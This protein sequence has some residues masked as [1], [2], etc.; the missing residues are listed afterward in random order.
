[1]RAAMSAFNTARRHRPRSRSRVPASRSMS[2]RVAGLA[3]VGGL[4]WALSDPGAAQNV[5]TQGNQ[6]PAIQAGGNVTVNYNAMSPEE[7]EAFAKQI[8]DKLLEAMKPQ[9]AQSAGPNASQRVDQAVS[10]IAE[11]ASGG[12]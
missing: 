7:K 1:M 8:T 12:D 2:L 11:G 6:S 9:G 4:L 10:S 5:Q 3:L